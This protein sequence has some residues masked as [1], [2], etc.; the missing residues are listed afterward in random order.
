MSKKRRSDKGG[1]ARAVPAG[2]SSRIEAIEAQDYRALGDLARS[3]FLDGRMEEARQVA[4]RLKSVESPSSELWLK[5]AETFSFL[6]DDRA[7]LDACRRAEAA[8]AADAQGGHPLLHHLAAVASW[9]LEQ[10]E[11][12]LKYWVTCLEL[13][14][15]FELAHENLHDLHRPDSERNGAWAFAIQSLLRRDRI[16]Q[17]MTDIRKILGEKSEFSAAS[18]KRFLKRNH[19]TVHLIPYLLERG[20]PIGREFAVRL[21][22]HLATPELLATLR[23]FA[24][25]RYGADALRVKAAEAAVQVDLLPRG[26]VKMWVA[27]RQQDV[28]LLGFE[29]HHQPLRHGSPEVEQ[30]IAAGVNALYQDDGAESEKLLKQALELAPDDPL[31]LN[32]L[33]AAYEAQGKSEAGEALLEETY[34]RFP[35]YL[36]ARTNLAHSYARRGRI[37]EAEALVEPLLNIRRLHTSELASLCGAQIEIALAHRNSQAAHDWFQMWMHADPDHRQ[38]ERYRSRV[39]RPDWRR[40]LSSSG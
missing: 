12:A 7:A 33:A 15:G 34:R 30:L 38:Q 25:G 29:V 6:G 36:F 5:M 19:E 1:G 8:G 28:L 18:L 17:M 3:L 11:Q 37:D 13:S 35:D 39:E 9:R 14:P 31:V 26:H 20:D 23:D 40:I 4:D 21:A 27:G 32:N 2:G 22:S 16:N 10:E 24:L